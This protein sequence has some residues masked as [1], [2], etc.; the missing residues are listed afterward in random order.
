MR[1]TPSQYR[2]MPW[3]NGGGATTEL[4]IRP[5]GASVSERFLFRVS[6]ADV[7]ASGPF[8]RFPGSDRHLVVIQGEGMTLHLGGARLPLEPFQP[9]FFS[10]DDAAE[11]QLTSGPVRDFNVIVDRARVTASL[12]VTRVATPLHLDCAPGATNVVHLLE[13]SLSDAQA[14][15]TLVLDA[16][17]DL[18]PG[19]AFSRMVLVQLH[20]R[21]VAA[22]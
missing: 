16:P 20:P 10:G 1:L 11:G 13:G 7:A 12:S 9:V 2:T 8:S 4:V 21:A 5:D 15:D 18:H 17:V 22:R 14:G 3:K 19:A 6:I